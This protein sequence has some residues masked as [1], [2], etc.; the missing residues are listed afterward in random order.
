MA[1]PDPTD[2]VLA[3]LRRLPTHAAA[4]IAADT[5]LIERGILD[6]IAILD[7]VSFLEESF[8][9]GL[10]LDDFVPENF[11][12]AVAIARMVARLGGGAAAGSREN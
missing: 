7:L 12:T 2:I 1:Q 6:S 9:F 3:W 8:H 10:P 4:E 5:E 11:C